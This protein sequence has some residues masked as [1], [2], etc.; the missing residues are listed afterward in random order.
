MKPFTSLINLF[1]SKKEFKVIVVISLVAFFFKLYLLYKRSLY[2][3]PDEGYYLILARNLLEGKGYAFNRLPNIM[4]PPFLPLAIALF[5]SIFRNLQLALNII[6]ALSGTLLGVMTYLIARKM[7]LS[8]FL[9][10]VCWLL[11]LFVYQLNSFLPVSAHYTRILYRGSDILNC[12]LIVTSA[13]LTLLLI[14]KDKYR[15]SILAGVFFSLAYLTRPEG[16]LLF[17]GLFVLL[18]LLKFSSFI[19]L[20]FKRIVCLAFIFLLFS[21]P[22]IFYEKKITGRWVISGKISA[23]QEYRESLL[24]VVK[25]EN[26]VPFMK[27]HYSLNKEST[28]MNDLYFGYHSQSDHREKFPISAFLN[29]KRAIANLRLYGIIPKTLFPL[30]LVPFF[31]IGF[32]VGVFNIV[33][34]KSP[35]DLVLLFLLPYSLAIEVLSYPIPRH[36]LFLIP[37]FILYAT[38]GLF[39]IT[40]KIFPRNKTIQKKVFLLVFIIFFIFVVYDYVISSTKNLLNIPIYKNSQLVEVEISKRLKHAGAE[41]IMSSHPSFAVRAFSDW[42]VLPIAPLATLLQFGQRKKVDYIIL[43]EEK[44]FFYDVLDMKNSFIPKSPEDSFSFSVLEKGNFFALIK[45]IKKE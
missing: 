16:F 33:K 44:T 18:L 14:E 38:E 4:F 20:S 7:K 11:V 36:H 15:F 12:F 17:V 35:F 28:E 13:Y 5:Y 2:I 39:F 37:V 23:S 6:T 32:F 21:F 30:P 41:I 45:L 34:R 10:F 29:L 19:S 42:Q 27:I 40:L 43:R 25:N 3:D 24:E 1:R 26:W 9:S 31:I 8:L 22:Y